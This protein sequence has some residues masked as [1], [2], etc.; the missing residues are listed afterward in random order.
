MKCDF[1]YKDRGH[2]CR[3]VGHL[4]AD[5][6]VSVSQALSAGKGGNGWKG[7][8][9]IPTG[10]GAANYVPRPAK[11]VRPKGKG[12]GKSPRKGAARLG[13]AGAA[14]PAVEAENWGGEDRGATI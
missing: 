5:R 8:G 6:A 7:Q 14:E 12:K 4:K 13:A 1:Y 11:G 9:K 10:N 3:G 2:D